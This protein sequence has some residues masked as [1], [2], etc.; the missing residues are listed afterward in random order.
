MLENNKI[1]FKLY[2]DINNYGGLINTVNYALKN[3]G[4]KLK[5]ESC[6]NN[7]YT[8][9]I[10]KNKGRFSQVMIASKERKFSTDLWC[11]GINYG[12]WWFNNIDQVANFIMY[13]V[14][15]E[16]TVKEMKKIFPWF[17]SKKGKLHEK[18][19][20]YEVKYQW[21]EIKKKVKIEKSPIKYLLPCILLAKEFKELKVLFPFTS[22]NTLC[23]SLTTGFP[24]LE[25]GPRIIAREKSNFDIEFEKENRISSKS[26]YEL[27]QNIKMNIKNYGIAR[28]GTA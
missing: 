15:H 6:S 5:S 2:T 4:S 20:K 9:A 10:V 21:S 7:I 14:E 11:D 23:F 24:Y 27:K 19:S 17:Y 28:Q 12:N 22:I 18:G 13:F 1:D 26:L 8:Y 16:L 25:V 3:I